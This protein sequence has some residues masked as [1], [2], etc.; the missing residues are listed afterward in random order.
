MLGSERDPFLKNSPEKNRT[1]WCLNMRLA[2]IPFLLVSTLLLA[3]LIS[4]GADEHDYDLQAETKSDL[5]VSINGFKFRLTK[6]NGYLTD[7]SLALRSGDNEVS[8]E[9]AA[10][11]A[12]V[13]II[14][15]KGSRRLSFWRMAV[16]AGEATKSS[17]RR[18]ARDFRYHWEK[19]DRLGPLEDRDRE[20]IIGCVERYIG[21]VRTGSVDRILAAP[22][23]NHRIANLAL[24]ESCSVAKAKKRFSFLHS[25]FLSPQMRSEFEVPEEPLVVELS[26][27]NSRIVIVCRKELRPLLRAETPIGTYVKYFF[28][29]ARRDGTWYMQ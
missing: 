21:W 19:A 24:T 5:L 15:W 28:T 8:V 4:W 18:Q 25:E 29:F 20:A 14:K 10:A 27:S 23:M 11:A 1:E 3:S 2:K 6:A 26:P 16:L 12:T 9:A 13:S 22:F 17:F 7:C